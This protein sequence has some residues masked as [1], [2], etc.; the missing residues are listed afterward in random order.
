MTPL[1]GVRMA[2]LDRMV[3]DCHA[4]L[5][6]HNQSSINIVGLWP[7]P[8]DT[9]KFKM[10]DKISNAKQDELFDHNT[11]ET[12]E[13]PGLCVRHLM[14]DPDISNKS[15]RVFITVDIAR[16]FGFLDVNGKMPVDFLSARN[17][18]LFHGYSIAS[19]VPKWL[20][21]PKFLFTMMQH[22]F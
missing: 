10:V 14:S 17:V 19:W 13:F 3:Q 7:G 16:E 8:V 20:Q 12:A 21:V 4:E 11:R 6:K 15:G 1:Y 22:K 18:L 9:E 5:R 2:A